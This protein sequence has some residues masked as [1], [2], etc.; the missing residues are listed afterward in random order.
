MKDIETR[1]DIEKLVDLFYTRVRKDALI[2]HFFNQV[3]KLD[4]E[5]HIPVICDFWESNLFGGKTYRG[6]PMDKHFALHERSPLRTAHFDRWLIVWESTIRGHFSGKN[7]EELIRRAAQ[8]AELMK[9]RI[10]QHGKL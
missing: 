2:G 10:G 6:N 8:I 1:A 7:A 4:W 3:V 9:Y 5:A